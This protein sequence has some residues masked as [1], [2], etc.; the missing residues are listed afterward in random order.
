MDRLLEVGAIREVHYSEWFANTTAI[1]KKWKVC[2]D[3]TDLNKPYP[4]DSF[5]LPRIDQLVDAIVGYKHMSFL[6][7]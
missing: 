4:K 6:D 5:L 3:F 7:A 2:M 1:K